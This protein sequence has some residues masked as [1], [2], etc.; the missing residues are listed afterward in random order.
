MLGPK[1]SQRLCGNEIINVA[2]LFTSPLNGIADSNFWMFGEQ[3][4]D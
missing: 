4:I 2:Y 3:K 1:V